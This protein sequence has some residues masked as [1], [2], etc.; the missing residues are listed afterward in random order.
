[1]GGGVTLASFQAVGNILS[2]IDILKIN[3]RGC[4]ISC[5]PAFNMKLVTPSTLQDNVELKEPIAF[6]MSVTLNTLKSKTGGHMS[7]M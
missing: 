7:G 6:A 1:M 3:S 2:L 5:I 4:R